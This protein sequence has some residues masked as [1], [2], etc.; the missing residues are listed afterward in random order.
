M[1]VRKSC[2]HIATRKLWHRLLI[3]FRDMLL[4][5]NQVSYSDK[6]YTSLKLLSCFYRSMAEVLNMESRGSPQAATAV[7]CGS[8]AATESAAGDLSPFH[9]VR[10]RAGKRSTCLCSSLL[11]VLVLPSHSPGTP[12]FPTWEGCNTGSW[13]TFLNS[14]LC[15][16][17]LPLYS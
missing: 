9:A 14:A 11:L 1:N 6:S 16:L 15:P 10:V 7:S 8:Q 13:W 5:M 2:Q 3:F 4:E 17:F 12:S